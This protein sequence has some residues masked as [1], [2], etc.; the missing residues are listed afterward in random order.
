MDSSF[1]SYSD[2]ESFDSMTSSSLSIKSSF[3]LCNNERKQHNQIILNIQSLCQS[4]DKVMSLDSFPEYSYDL[5]SDEPALK[6]TNTTTDIYT[7]SLFN[8]Q[9]LEKF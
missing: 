1:S 2:S 8:V 9:R 5:L 7:H 6:N 3:S 4:K